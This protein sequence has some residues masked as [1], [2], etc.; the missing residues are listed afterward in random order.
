M[1]ARRNFTDHEIACYVLGIERAIPRQEVEDAL[2]HDNAA[3]ARALKWEAY[4]LGIVDALPPCAPDETLFAQIEST[5]G[6]QGLTPGSPSPAPAATSRPGMGPDGHGAYQDMNAG[7]DA[8]SPGQRRARRRLA[9]WLRRWRLPVALALLVLAGVLLLVVWA[10]L[11]E[12][13]STMVSEA[14]HLLDPR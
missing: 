3:A 6:M 11:R 10:G 13:P 7:A 1:K 9:S 12:V 2:A 8:P 5:L 14:V 4:F